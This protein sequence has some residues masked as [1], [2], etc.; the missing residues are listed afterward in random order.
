M[1]RTLL[2]VL[3]ACVALAGCDLLV[4]PEKRV[5]RAAA[6]IDKGDYRAAAIELRNALQKAPDNARGRLL[7]AQTAYWLGDLPAAKKELERAADAGLPAEQASRLDAEIK[8]AF[9][10]F[11]AVEKAMASKPAG[12]DEWQRLVF[13]GGAQLGQRKSMLRRRRSRRR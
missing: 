2:V 1:T 5:E 6:L 4:S 11:D 9:G 8:L 10:E 7:M 12:L 3:A 13:L